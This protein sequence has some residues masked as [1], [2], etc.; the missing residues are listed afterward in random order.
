MGKGEGKN[1]GEG[2][3]RRSARVQGRKKREGEEGKEEG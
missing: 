3:V 2:R 1:G